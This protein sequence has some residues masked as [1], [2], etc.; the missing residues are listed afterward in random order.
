[1]DMIIPQ[2]LLDLY[3]N[4]WIALLGMSV[5][6]FMGAVA[7]AF[8]LFPAIAGWRIV[9]AAR[10]AFWAEMFL[11]GLFLLV[12]VLQLNLESWRKW[13]EKVEASKKEETTWSW[14]WGGDKK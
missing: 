13:S 11:I 6:I 14:A 12:L 5:G 9:K 1:M 10:R 4:W 2:S 3:A 7:M 8:I